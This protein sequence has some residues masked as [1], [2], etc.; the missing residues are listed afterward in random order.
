MDGT[1]IHAL[2]VLANP[3][4][5]VAALCAVVVITRASGWLVRWLDGTRHIPTPAVP[6][7]ADP[8]LTAWLRGGADAAALCVM[9]QLQKRGLLV[10]QTIREGCFRSRRVRQT[11]GSTDSALTPLEQCVWAWFAEDRRADSV[12]QDGLSEV[13]AP[14]TERLA[15]RCLKLQ[16]TTTE[17]TQFA[18]NL[19]Q[20]I[21]IV[22]I[23]LLGGGGVALTSAPESFGLLFAGT[24][25]FGVC[26]QHS[27]S[28]TN[29]LTDLGK[30]T[31]Q[32]LEGE[33]K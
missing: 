33:K 10:E 13:V 19:V 25:L 5:L 24:T 1:A 18:C 21:G 32:R 22:A 29:R 27:V 23:L 14:Q 11:P 12:L 7:D 6:A 2:K 28:R 17:E 16:L 9:Q 8:V 20:G 31:L 4:L 30:R 26:L 15:Q 3:A